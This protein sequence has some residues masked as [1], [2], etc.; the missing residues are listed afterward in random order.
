MSEF[1]IPSSSQP[2]SLEHLSSNYEPGESSSAGQARRQQQLVLPPPPNICPHS[3]I[4]NHK[5]NEAIKTLD[6]KIQQIRNAEGHIEGEL[7]ESMRQIRENISQAKTQLE[8]VLIQLFEEYQT[9]LKRYHETGL[10]P[11]QD[12][13]E[14]FGREL[15]K[16]LWIYEDLTYGF[17]RFEEHD[18]YS[19]QDLDKFMQEAFP[20]SLESLD[21]HSL[22]KDIHSLVELYGDADY[23]RKKSL[24]Q[25]I[26]SALNKL[27]TIVS[28]CE[29]IIQDQES[30]V[31]MSEKIARR[32]IVEAIKNSDN[33]EALLSAFENCLEKCCEA[34][35]AFLELINHQSASA[36]EFSEITQRYVHTQECLEALES[37]KRHFAN[38]LPIIQQMVIILENEKENQLPERYDD[39]WDSHT[40]AALEKECERLNGLEESA[41][42][43]LD[44]STRLNEEIVLYSEKTEEEE[45]RAQALENRGRSFIKE[46]KSLKNKL[47]PSHQPKERIQTLR[48]HP[49]F[50]DNIDACLTTMIRLIRKKELSLE[51]SIK[52]YDHI[53]EELR[54]KWEQLEEDINVGK[55]QEALI[56]LYI[57][58][59]RLQAK[60]YSLW[61]SKVNVASEFIKRIG[62]V[63]DGSTPR[64]A[65]YATT[66]SALYGVCA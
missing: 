66:P 34:S 6:W 59:Q 42:K 63:V 9:A 58:I 5:F 35:S 25:N 33:G 17:G 32:D 49:D 46:L 31:R 28:A 43:I 22:R 1:R 65:V 23:E 29:E 56:D 30:S 64:Q 52:Q 11:F 48:K 26:R 38:I 7:E 19:K 12:Q 53:R 39:P 2:V 54:K 36:L 55:D 60:Y 40:V 16:S 4:T 44:E 45:V 50:I 24:C 21:I 61:T 10:E 3:Q 18:G 47:K 41:T 51:V 62:N 8:E 20:P 13:L 15:Q 57:E 27:E 37:M 14:R